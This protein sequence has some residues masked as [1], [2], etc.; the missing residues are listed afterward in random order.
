MGTNFIVFLASK[1]KPFL[2]SNKK[3]GEYKRVR[4]SSLSNLIYSLRFKARTKIS[5]IS[6][7]KAIA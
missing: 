4:A 7:R 6:K 2:T 3:I 5:V 1:N